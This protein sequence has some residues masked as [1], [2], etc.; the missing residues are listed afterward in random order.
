[1]DVKYSNAFDTTLLPKSKRA[2]FSQVTN[3]PVSE[4]FAAATTELM[5]RPQQF[6]AQEMKD[7]LWSL[8]RVRIGAVLFAHF[9]RTFSNYVLYLFGKYWKQRLK[10]AILEYSN[11]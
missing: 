1:M 10:C 9:Q 2:S 11:A 5:R 3:D 4:C 7:V 8:S 6:K